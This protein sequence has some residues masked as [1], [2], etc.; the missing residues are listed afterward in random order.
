MDRIRLIGGNELRGEIPISGAKN[1][2]LP[3]R[4]LYWE[5]HLEDS[6]VPD[7]KQAVRWKNWK[8]V[9]N[10]ISQ[11]VE[12]YDLSRDA[13]ETINRAA[14]EPAIARRLTDMMQQAHTESTYW[15]VTTAK[16]ATQ[17]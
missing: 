1:A 11:P 2:A 14:N 3:T 7:M 10:S 5:F 6:K 16:N 12:L 15:P 17:R 4:S 8:A 9:R 13:K